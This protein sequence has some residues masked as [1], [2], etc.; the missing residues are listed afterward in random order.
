MPSMYHY[1]QEGT[2]L[3]MADVVATDFA[4]IWCQLGEEPLHNTKWNPTMAFYL[5]DD[6]KMI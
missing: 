2:D 5:A 4:Q 1:E 6:T 3:T